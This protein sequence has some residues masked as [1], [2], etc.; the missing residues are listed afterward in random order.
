MKIRE[1]TRFATAAPT[2][3]NSYAEQ[4]RRTNHMAHKTINTTHIDT[5]GHGYLS[6]SKKDIIDLGIMPSLFSTFSGQTISRVYLEEDCDATAFLEAAKAQGVEVKI[7]SGYN[8]SFSCSHN[9]NPLL[10]GW[11]PNYGDCVVINNE[12]YKIVQLNDKRLIVEGL[13]NHKKYTVPLSNPFKYIQGV[14][15]GKKVM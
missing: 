8:L 4:N 9:Y 12:E 7:K 1:S 6:V 15:Y 3:L 11:I 13:D 10:F 2:N 5:G 14:L